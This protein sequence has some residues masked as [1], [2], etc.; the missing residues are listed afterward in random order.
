MKFLRVWKVL[1][2]GNR[3][4]ANDE[5]IHPAFTPPLPPLATSFCLDIEPNYER[6]FYP[7]VLIYR[8]PSRAVITH[9]FIYRLHE[10]R[11]MYV[12]YAVLPGKILGESNFC[13]FRA[14]VAANNDV[15]FR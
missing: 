5:P 2:P 14:S 15:E 7:L 8:F 3:R 4:M 13:A 10:L 6:S 11:F 9:R 12:I 1:T